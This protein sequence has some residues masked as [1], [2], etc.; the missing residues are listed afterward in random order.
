MGSNH[1]RISQHFP[2]RLHIII[3]HFFRSPFWNF[4]VCL[5]FYSQSSLQFIYPPLFLHARSPLL[6]LQLLSVC[7]T[8]NFLLNKFEQHTLSSL[9][10]HSVLLHHSRLL[11]VGRRQVSLRSRDTEGFALLRLSLR[12]KD[13]LVALYGQFCL[14]RIYLFC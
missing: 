1:F 14:Y 10:N 5:D 9:V 11:E 4:V 6:L 3:D 13:T 2:K 8:Y 12:S 7:T